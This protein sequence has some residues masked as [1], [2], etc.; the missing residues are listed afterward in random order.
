M[1]RG[2]WPLNHGAFRFVV[3]NFEDVW[4]AS[5]KFHSLTFEELCNV[6][7]DDQLHVTK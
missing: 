3:R 7:R 4:T 5:P 1:S 6:L 2:Y